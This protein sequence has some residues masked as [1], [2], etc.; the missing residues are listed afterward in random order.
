MYIANWVRQRVSN[1]GTGNINLGTLLDGFI[2]FSSAFVNGD[3]IH[4]T[5]EDGYN[6]EVGIGVYNSSSNSISRQQILETLV[7]GVHDKSSPSAISLTSNTIVGVDPST[8]AL[9]NHLPVWKDLH[10]PLRQHLDTGL[11]TPDVI[12]FAGIKALGFDSELNESMSFT[13][14]LNHDG[15][16]GS[17]IIPYIAWSPT[18]NN[19]GVVRWGI[20]FTA[21]QR[22]QGTFN[23]AVVIYLEQSSQSTKNLNLFIEHS[24]SILG[25]PEPDTVLVGSVFRDASHENDTYPDDAVL[26]IAGMHYQANAVG[27]PSKDPDYFN[28]G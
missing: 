21:A 24:A 2:P 5:L 22:G 3:T 26:H 13:V 6:R 11:A 25:F 14:S 4:Y 9:I 18:T 19:A 1:T 15:K 17:D 28:W 12:D 8:Q 23:D 27:T 20:A 10:L 16:V 7:N